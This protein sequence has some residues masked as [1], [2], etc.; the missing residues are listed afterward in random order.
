M[1]ATTLSQQ[2][3]PRTPELSP[4]EAEQFGPV[5]KQLEADRDGFTAEDVVLAARDPESPLH[6]WFE[7]DDSVAAHM[8]RL[9]RASTLIRSIEVVI[10]DAGTK[11]E[12]AVRAFT[13]FS[14]VTTESGEKRGG[15]RSTLAITQQSAYHYN[16]ERGITELKRWRDRYKG[17]PELAEILAAIDTRIASLERGQDEGAE[18]VDVSVTEVHQ[19]APVP[20]DEP[21]STPYT[22]DYDPETDVSDETTWPWVGD[23]VKIVDGEHRGKIGKIVEFDWEASQGTWVELEDRCVLAEGNF[24]DALEYIELAPRD[25]PVEQPEP[26]VASTVVCL[27]KIL[28]YK[29]SRF[30]DDELE[31]IKQGKDTDDAWQ[32][33]QEAFPNSERPFHSVKTRWAKH[34]NDTEGAR[35]RAEATAGQKIVVEMKDPPRIPKRLEAVLDK[36]EDKT[37]TD[38]DEFRVG[39]KVMQARGKERV[40]G[41]GFIQRIDPDKR[42]LQALVKFGME[43]K[44]IPVH[45]LDVV[46]NGNSETATSQSNGDNTTIAAEPELETDVKDPPPPERAFFVGAKVKQ[47]KGKM[48]GFGPGDVTQI[49]PNGDLIV[50]FFKCQRILPKDHFAFWEPKKK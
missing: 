24:E 44:W 41:T 7:W 1:E 42:P 47:I 33:Y 22:C 29:G 5:L 46:P 6:P 17:Y 20:V 25:A 39:M 4:E 14:F 3:R 16:L 2:F 12:E 13:L 49:R 34:W 35:R 40:F 30:R 10:V 8:Y 37:G 28:F 21:H 50:E 43:M 15:Y 9:E 48:P 36:E 32:R 18:A 45:Y 23:T 31:V 27:E 19:A 38:P 26:T 11:R